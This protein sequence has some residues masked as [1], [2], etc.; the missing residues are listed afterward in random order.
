MLLQK[1]KDAAQHIPIVQAT[2][3]SVGMNVLFNLV[4]KAAG[5]L[6]SE[7]DVEIVEQHHRFKKD[8]PSARP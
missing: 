3:M 2:N 8:S 5:M 4:G 6:G 7:Y 1:V